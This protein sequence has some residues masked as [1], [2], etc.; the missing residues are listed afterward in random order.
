MK[1]GKRIVA[2]S[3]ASMIG[4]GVVGCNKIEG[5]EKEVKVIRVAHGQNEDHPEHKAMLEFEKYVEEKTNGELDVQIFPNELLGA[6]AQAV[7]LS[8]TGAVDLV[9]AGLGTLEAFNKSY[10]VLNLP[11]IMDSTEHYHEVM[12]DE[13]IM[14][15]V[16]ESTRQSG[17]VGLTWFDAGSRSIYTT[18][19]AIMKPEDL[20]GLK[21]RVQASASNVKMIQALGASPTPMSFGEVYTGLQQNVI[22]GAE[23]NEL[24][25]INNKHGEVAKYYSYNMHA[26]LPDM[27]IASVDLLENK[28][29]E[30]Q[31]KIVMEA[32]N[33]A[34]EVEVSLWEDAAAEAK[35][36]AEEMGVQFYYPDIKPFQ[37]KM[38]NL[39]AEYTKDESM[40]SMYDKIRAKGDEILAKKENENKK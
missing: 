40:K 38:K 13:E 4:F 19:K 32:A 9:V 23:N 26:M 12:N 18:K 25:L 7:E 30:E 21:I 1:L 11:Y 31:A 6:T 22:D 33:Y 24:A 15:P 35:A 39:H 36:K 20:K 28:L 27:L 5:A 10:T 17:F 16:Y 3:I 29:T 2:L 34:N 37:E 8:Q 14:K